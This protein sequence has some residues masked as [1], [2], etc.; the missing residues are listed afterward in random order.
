[1]IK[2]LEWVKI[3][4]TSAGGGLDASNKPLGHQKDI[5]IYIKIVL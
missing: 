2:S 1:M 3:S 4:I 5:P